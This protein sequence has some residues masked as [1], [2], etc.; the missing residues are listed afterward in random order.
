M[1]HTALR[2]AKSDKLVADNV[3]SVLAKVESFSYLGAE[4]VFNALK[5]DPVSRRAALGR[6]L[7]F[8]AN[9]RPY[10]LRQG[11]CSESGREQGW[12]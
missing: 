12:R 7:R 1:L 6:Q 8:Y 11:Y 3:D 2:S 9:Q 4:L 5:T 10:W